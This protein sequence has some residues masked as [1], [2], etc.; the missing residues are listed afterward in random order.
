M[1]VPLSYNL[2]SAFVRKGATALTVSA[3]A[4]SVA[5]LVMVLALARGFE[6]A[7]AGTG[8]DDNVIVLR[9][10]STS[11]GVSGLT[12][13][14]ARI[15]QAASFVA[16]DPAGRPLAQPELYAA[17]NLSR[18]DG[19][20]TNIPVRGTGP[21]GLALRSTVRIQ[22]GGR[23]FEP[24]KYE[25]VVG[26]SLVGRVPGCQLGGALTL[27]NYT[28]QVVG[29]ADSA[30]QAYDSEIW[31]DV[32]IFL[33]LL[34]RPGF[35]TVIARLHAPGELPALRR[36]VE[37]DPRLNVTVKTERQYFT[38][39]AGALATVLKALAWFL[40]AI[41][42]TGAVFGATNTLLANV[43][44]RR[45][46]I[47]TLLAIGFSPRQVFLGFLTE[48]LVLAVV[49]G[50]LGVALGYQCNGIATGTTNWS[51]FT[52]Q[53]F[54]FAVT[55]DVVASAMVLAAFIG[56]IGGALPAAR[57]ARL[58]PREALRAL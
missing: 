35:S 8:T 19:G 24:G 29:V 51:T 3:I 54:S 47:G 48:S 9:S 26:R 14:T 40:A 20:K 46:E 1:A 37:D 12:R 15:L 52:E 6:T 55:P 17:F 34:D 49:G 31:L 39:Q 28:W 11:E 2:R 45:R 5:V 32:E 23:M 36:R 25:I 53:S 56:L 58:T 7:L 42:G 41:M 50:V 4:F 27:S 44:M 16:R 18:A 22:P 43:S 30:G 13:D 57:A 10:G 21:Q 33:R 38:E